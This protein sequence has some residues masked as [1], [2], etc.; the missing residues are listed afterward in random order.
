MSGGV[1]EVHEPALAQH[2]DR[3]ARGQA[4]LVHLRLDLDLLGALERLE[5]GHVDLVV[6]VADVRDDREVLHGEHVLDCG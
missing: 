2:E 5:R 6:E 4:P 3:S 1:A